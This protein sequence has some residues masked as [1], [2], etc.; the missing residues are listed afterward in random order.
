M[1]QD[2]FARACSSSVNTGLIGLNR[3]VRTAEKR[4]MEFADFADRVAEKNS[5]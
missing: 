5:R 1:N 2:A 4:F 3:E